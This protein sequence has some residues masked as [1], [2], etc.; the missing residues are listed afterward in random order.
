MSGDMLLQSLWLHS[1]LVKMM[2]SW[3]QIKTSHGW[4][5]VLIA[6]MSLLWIQGMQNGQYRPGKR[7]R[8]VSWDFCHSYN[9]E[10]GPVLWT[11]LT[12]AGDSGQ[13]WR[14]QKLLQLWK[15]V[16]PLLIDHIDIYFKEGGKIDISCNLSLE[17]WI[18]PNFMTKHWHQVILYHTESGKNFH[19]CC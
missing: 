19:I 11:I 14:A 6:A 1:S 10:F 7:G 16:E 5:V 8:V 3:W 15:K 13:Y 12:P 18:G 9:I 4:T 17:H 2:A